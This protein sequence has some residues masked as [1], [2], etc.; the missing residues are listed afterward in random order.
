MFLRREKIVK[1]KSKPKMQIRIPHNSSVWP[2]IPPR[3]FTL[4]RSGNFRLASPPASCAEAAAA[5]SSTAVPPA[6]N[7]KN[8]FKLPEL[9]WDQAFCSQVRMYASSKNK[10]LNVGSAS[11]LSQRFCTQITGNRPRARCLA[12]WCG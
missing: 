5:E 4:E 1:P 10:V 3:N 7:L 9:Q 8:R 12:N 11:F 2:L 6:V